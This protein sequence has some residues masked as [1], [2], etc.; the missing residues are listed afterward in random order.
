MR[1]RDLIVG[2][3]AL[4]LLAV[5]QPKGRV[6]LVGVLISETLSG[7]AAR[8]EALRAGLRERGY[9]VEARSIFLEVRAAEGSYDKLP[10]MAAELVAL[11]V[12]VLVAFGGKATFAAKRAT[13]TVPVVFVSVTDPISVG[14]VDSLSKPGG[15]ITGV[16]NFAELSGKQLEQLKQAA[17]HAVRAGL[18]VNPANP[19]R[20]SSS[21]GMRDVAKSLKL[22]L[23]RFEVRAPGELAAA[24]SAMTRNHV[25]SLWVSG[26][27]LFQPRFAE[28][29]A[30]A[31]K[32]RLPAVGRPEFAEAGG[33][34]GYGIDDLG[35]F[36]RASYFVERLLK[37]ARPADL[38]IERATKFELVI[39][40]RTAQTMGIKI[41]Q[42][43]LVR[44]D[45]VIE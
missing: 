16:S 25:D 20:Q 22:E 12:D 41:P 43:L 6:P 38:P 13:A 18:L 44:A 4:P 19:G 26:D 27:T 24:F 31:V 42:S 10:S 36:R 37:G 14:I 32:H 23:H 7:Q 28:I 35:Q 34:L 33:L 17:P 40:Q 8:I 15:N 2:G 30:L 39:N 3:L 29:A 21:E 11:K 1:R 45:R 9:S 5:A